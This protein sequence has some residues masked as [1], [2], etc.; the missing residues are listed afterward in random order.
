MKNKN[1]I[2]LGAVNAVLILSFI[3][4]LISFKKKNKK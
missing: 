1:F 4:L 3:G 2:I